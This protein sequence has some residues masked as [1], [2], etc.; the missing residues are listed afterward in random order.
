MSAKIRS[1]LRTC[2]N[3]N[4][5]MIACARVDHV[6]VVRQQLRPAPSNLIRKIKQM[7]LVTSLP[8]PIPDKLAFKFVLFCFFFFCLISFFFFFFRECSLTLSPY[9][10]GAVTQH[11]FFLF[12]HFVFNHKSLTFYK[13]FFLSLPASMQNIK[14][15]QRLV[16]FVRTCIHPPICPEEEI[17]LTV[18]FQFFLFVYFG[19]SYVI[20]L[21]FRHF[22]NL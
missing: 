15:N 14:Y 11:R 2:S 8:K 5:S 21:Y 1:P 18:F 17:F 20:S 9:L 6:G 19:V 16:Q 3:L 4:V 13:C 12:L 10:R 22:V 7:M